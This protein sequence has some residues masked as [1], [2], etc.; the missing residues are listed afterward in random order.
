ML[1]APAALEEF[2]QALGAEPEDFS[3]PDWGASK[4][5]AIEGTKGWVSCAP[6][7]FHVSI[8]GYTSHGQERAVYAFAKFARLLEIGD[9][10]ERLF[11]MAKP[12][13]EDEAKML[14]RWLG[15]RRAK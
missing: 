11:L 3:P 14:R 10:G 1:K 15:L 13:N 8:H 6:G 7:G 4:E 5:W 9:D 2:R 12:P